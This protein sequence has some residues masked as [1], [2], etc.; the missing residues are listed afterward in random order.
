MRR[1]A[2]PFDEIDIGPELLREAA[3]GGRDAFDALYDALLPVVWSLASREARSSNR[4]EALTRSILRRVVGE[5][6]TVSASEC[7]PAALLDLIEAELDAFRAAARRA[8]RVRPIAVG[9]APGR[10]RSTRPL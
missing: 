8:A 7:A 2:S 3:R 4:A 6:E 5:L 10:A 9:R 1:R